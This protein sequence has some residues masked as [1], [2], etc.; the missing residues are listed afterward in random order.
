MLYYQKPAAF[1]RKLIRKTP[2][3][4]DLCVS[5]IW[6]LDQTR[7]FLLSVSKE[8][9]KNWALF[10]FNLSH[11][12]PHC[13]LGEPCAGHAQRDINK[14][15]H[16]G[17]GIEVTT[18]R[19]VLSAATQRLYIESSILLSRLQ[20]SGSQTAGSDLYLSIQSF[21]NQEIFRITVWAEVV[22]STCT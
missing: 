22:S 15:A 13:S 17:N 9:I 8:K 19:Q 4:T 20:W 21:Q 18:Y 6:L 11:C 3:L 14:Q 2:V 1:H 7:S 16:H 5:W 10:C 12:V